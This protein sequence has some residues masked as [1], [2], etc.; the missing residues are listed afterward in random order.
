VT[1]YE[2]LRE[3]LLVCPKAWLVTGG[4]GFIGSHLLEALLR[5][6]QRVIGLD[7][8][9]T[10][11]RKN[12]DDVQG[13][14]AS[15]QWANFL[16]IDGDIRDLETCR[17]ASLGVDFVLHHAALDSVTGS[18]TNPDDTHASNVNGFLN[19]LIAARDNK[20]RRVVY[21][22]SRSAYGDHPDSPSADY[23]LGRCLSPHAVTKRANELYAEAFARCYGLESIGLRYFNVFGA[24]QQATDGAAAVI[25]KW[26]AAL[27]RNESV[28]MNG[29]GNSAFA[30]CYVAN[31]IQAN[32]LAAAT[33]TPDAINEIYNIGPHSASN[34]NEFLRTLRQNLLNGHRRPKR[35][36]NLNYDVEPGDGLPFDADVSKAARLLGYQPTHTVEQ[37]LIEALPWYRQNFS[38]MPEHSIRPSRRKRMPSPDSVSAI[39]FST[40]HV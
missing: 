17:R 14:V 32:L 22:S 1:P 23:K 37:G 38:P 12:L 27:L 31:V 2:S 35:S 20:V 40:P 3:Q 19:I 5:L 11:S 36:R 21:A 13:L 7:N 8:Y 10:G 4:A 24:R 16:R 6:N 33:D 28:H 34:P 29:N 39:V 15:A 30:F 26:I 25:P 9:S 18:I